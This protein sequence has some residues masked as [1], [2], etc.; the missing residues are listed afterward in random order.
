[1]LLPGGE[2]AVFVPRTAII[3]DKTTDSY[4]VF[5]IDNNTAHL[6]V[7]VT[8]DIDGDQIRVTTGLSGAE[9]LATNHQTDLYDGAPVT[10]S[11]AEAR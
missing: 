10:T 3:R 11:L 4:Q 2:S 7:V 6:R 9:T 5:V 1:V 8:G